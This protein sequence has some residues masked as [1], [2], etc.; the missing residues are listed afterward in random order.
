MALFPVPLTVL[1]QRLTVCEPADKPLNIPVIV[2]ASNVPAVLNNAV[3]LPNEVA[4]PSILNSKTAQL[5][6]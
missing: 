1:A 4:T 5:P 6:Q 3:A 2:I